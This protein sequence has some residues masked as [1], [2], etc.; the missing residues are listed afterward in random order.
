MRAGRKSSAE[1]CSLPPACILVGG[2]VA[3]ANLRNLVHLEDFKD[4]LTAG[5]DTAQLVLRTAQ[6]IHLQDV[7]DCGVDQITHLQDV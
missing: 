7:V 6:P 3:N 4:L 1:A 2:K 5:D